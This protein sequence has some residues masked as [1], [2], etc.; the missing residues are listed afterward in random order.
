MFNCNLLFA[1]KF[2]GEA[3]E[4]KWLREALKN[5]IKEA[6]KGNPESQYIVGMHYLNAIYFEK[7]IASALNWIGEAKKNNY[8]KALEFYGD[9][10]NNDSIAE[11][12]YQLAINH[13]NVNDKYPISIQEIEYK[14]S[15]LNKN[16]RTTYLNFASKYLMGD[17][18]E[19]STIG[20]SIDEVEDIYDAMILSY[21][22]LA[23]HKLAFEERKI[24]YSENVYIPN[25]HRATMKARKALDFLCEHI[26]DNFTDSLLNTSYF[27]DK[28]QCY[29]LAISCSRI[30]QIPQY[31]QFL[32]HIHNK[33]I[34]IKKRLNSDMYLQRLELDYYEILY[35]LEKNN[36]QLVRESL[37]PKFEHEVA[38]LKNL[39]DITKSHI[40]KLYYQLSEFI[41]YCAFEKGEEEPLLMITALNTMIHSRD[42]E[43]YSKKGDDSCH[44]KLIDWN[45][46]KKHMASKS[47]AFM[48]FEYSKR[49]SW[50]YVW[51]FSPNSTIPK[52]V[53]GG[54]S[55]WSEADGMLAFREYKEMEKLYVVGTNSMMLTDF[56][57]DNRVIRLHSIS[58]ILN[59]KTHY[60]NEMVYV[61][62][63]INYTFN[64]K[65]IISETKGAIHTIGS[66]STAEK[67]VQAI[68]KA[69]GANTTLYQGNGVTRNLF[70]EICKKKGILHISTH[71]IFN[72]DLLRSLNKSNPM[73]GI[74]GENILRS[75]G[76]MLSGYNN[77]KYENFISAYDVKKMQ[78]DN[79]DL[80]FISACES[81]AGKVLSTGD[82]SLAEAFHL[83]GV[84]NIIAIIDPINEIVATKFA[85][86]FYKQISDKVSYHDAFYN[87][88][89]Q[90]CPNDRIILFE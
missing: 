21:S 26:D 30:L 19:C 22:S 9:I 18:Q 25:F 11:L 70:K 6:K 79:I 14:I 5:L 83:S 38:D 55:Y 12:Y 20:D 15:H 29:S 34:P 8:A 10:E 87:T 78:L 86:H 67:E 33:V 58:D 24:D 51:C 47:M 1:Q 80:V 54:H 31:R 45:E 41:N 61:I 84:K 62:G 82:Y 56:S 59:Q 64:K 68:R 65:D 71:G 4:D 37:L 74:T 57:N 48:F 44:F 40:A 66:F 85:E 75:C 88:K 90:I 2:I 7:D 27:I 52:V 89:N 72:K 3:K 46:I 50:N 39:D 76:L 32:N 63:K 23:N 53:Y 77:D 16:K 81:A 28:L 69:F 60:N 49:D 73:S 17:Y 43:F 35:N 13:F 36:I 42:Y